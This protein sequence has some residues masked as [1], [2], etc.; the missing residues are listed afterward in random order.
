MNL[1]PDWYE[2]TVLTSPLLGYCLSLV[3]YELLHSLNCN[4]KG[5]Q[6]NKILCI[7]CIF[8]RCPIIFIEVVITSTDITR[9]NL[10][11]ITN[12]ASIRNMSTCIISIM[13]P[14]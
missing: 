11:L 3:M 2:Q 7:I 14:G 9:R 10:M 13:H 12:G 8:F 5:K 1:Y 4:K 6:I